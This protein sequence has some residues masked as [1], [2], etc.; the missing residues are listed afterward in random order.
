MEISQNNI[1]YFPQM[2]IC[3]KASVVELNSDFS[4]PDYQPEIRRLLSSRAIVLP[5]HE[6]ISNGNVEIS[7]EINYKITYIF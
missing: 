5:Q 2:P 7:G 1:G 3:D 4:L 6:Y